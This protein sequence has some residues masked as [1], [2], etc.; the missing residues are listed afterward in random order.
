MVVEGESYRLRVFS[1]GASKY[2]VYMDGH[3]ISARFGDPEQHTARMVIAGR[4]LRAVHDVTDASIRVE[5]RTAAV[6]GNITTGSISVPGGLQ[7]PWKELN[8]IA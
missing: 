7:S 3:V 4:Y 5:A 2:R 8:L 6:L 1:I